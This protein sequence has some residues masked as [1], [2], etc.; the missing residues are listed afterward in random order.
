MMKRF[1]TAPI[2]SVRRL[3]KAAR[4]LPLLALLLAPLV[5]RA[6][7]FA[8]TTT[9]D[10]GMGSL[11]QAILAANAHPGADSIKFSIFDTGAQ[12]ISLSSPLPDITDTVTI[13]GTTQAGYMDRPVV[14]IEGSM[15]LTSDISGLTIRAANCVVRG[16]TFNRFGDAGISLQNASGALIE[17]CLFG[18]DAS[19]SFALGNS[20]GLL[21][22]NASN[23]TIRN[24]AFSGNGY[25]LWLTNQSNGNRITNC[26]IGTDFTGG[27]AVGNVYGIVCD[28]SSANIFDSDIISGNLYTGVT[29]E[30]GASGSQIT[31]CFIG[32]SAFYL[33]LPNGADGADI[34]DSGG[35]TLSNNIIDSNFLDGVL[36]QGTAAQ[37]NILTGNTIL[38]SATGVETQAG[39]SNNVIGGAAAAAGNAIFGNDVAGISISGDGSA[40][41][42]ISSNQIYSNGAY[43]VSI[44]S[45]DNQVTA[46]ILNGNGVNGVFV[47]ASDGSRYAVR[48]P[49]RFNSIYD[50]GDLGIWLDGKGASGANNLQPAPVL[51]T[52]SAVAGNALVLGT[53]NAAPNKT[54][55]IQFF[56]NF[57]PDPSGFGE[58]Q[59][60]LGSLNVTTNATGSASVNTTLNAVDTGLFLSSIVT[61]PD[62]N[63]SAFSNTLLVGQPNDVPVLTALDP[64]TAIVGGAGFTLTVTG[65]NFL[66]NS[67]VNWNGQDLPTQYV[68]ANKLTAT[69]P[70]SDLTSAGNVS[71]TV[72]NAP[73]GGGVSNPLTFTALNPLPAIAAL[74]P[75]SV[76]AGSPA[77]TLK[78]NGSNF[79]KSSVVR[80]N[81][82]DRATTFVSSSQLTIT[83]P[84]TDIATAGT[85]ALTV[86]SPTPG[87]GASAPVTFTINNPVPTL[88]S[89]LPGSAKAGSPSVTITLSGSNFVAK[90]QGQWN[91]A[92]RPTTYVSATQLTLTVPASDLITPG[93]TAVTVFNPAPG[94]GT[95]AAQ[96]FTVV[97]VPDLQVTT[98]GASIGGN[99]I[100]NIYTDQSFDVTWTDAN[101][102]Q[103]K[104]VGPWTDTVTLS[105]SA[106]PGGTALASFSYPYNGSLDAGQS[107]QRIQTMAIPRGNVPADGAYYLIVTTD[108]ANKVDEGGFEN[109]NFRAIP[110]YIAR[111]PLPDLIVAPNGIVAPDTA[112]DQQTITVQYSIKNQGHASTDA[113]Q[114]TD[115]IYLST[116]GQPGIEDAVKI[117]AQNVSY[118]NAGDSYTGSVQM[119]LPRGVVGD[120]YLSVYTDFDGSNHFN[121]PFSVVEED[122]TNNYFRFVNGAA[123][124]VRRPIHINASPYPDLQVTALTAPDTAFRGQPMTL[125]YTVANKG[126]LA[127]PSGQ[128][129]WQD[130]FYL[131]QSTT[132]DP[133]SARFIG[134]TGNLSGLAIGASYVQ[135]SATVTIPN[136]IAGDWYVVAYTDYQNNV[137]EFTAENNNTRYYLDNTGKPKTVHI[138]ANPPDLVIP[139]AV[140]APDTAIAN[141]QISVAWTVK[142]QGA[143]DATPGWFDTVYLT[144][145]TTPDPAK[146]TPLVTVYHDGTVAAGKSYATPATATV[147]IPACIAGTYALYVYTDSRSQIFEYDPNLNAEANNFSPLK[148]VVIT[149]IP[150]DLQVA[151]VT[152]PATGN[153]GQTIPVTFTV[154]NRGIGPT[155]EGSW[156]DTIYLSSSATFN[157]GTTTALA[158]FTHTGDLA[159]GA[160]YTDTES[161]TLPATAQG[162]YYVFVMTDSSNQV[163][164]CS[165]ENNNVGG[166]AVSIIVANQLPDLQINA[167]VA[168]PSAQVGQTISLQWTG[169]NNGQAAAKN[170]AW[171][172]GVYLTPASGGNAIRLATALISGPLAIGG[173]YSAQAQITIPPSTAP[174]SYLL[175]VTADADNFVYEGAYENNNTAIAPITIAAPNDDLQVTAVTA[176]TDAISGQTMSVSWTVKNAGTQPTPAAGWTDYVLL[177]RDQN[178]DASDTIVGYAVHSSV[179]AP[180]ATYTQNLNVTIPLGFSGPFYVFVYTD[181]KN[182]VAE[183]NEF[184]NVTI[185]PNATN[186]TL[187]PPTDLVVLPITPPATAAPGEPVTLNW[188]VKNQGAQTALGRW[189]DAVYFS[190]KSY[191]D[192]TATLVG[193]VD[194]VGN[195]AG[196]A[197]YNGTLTTELPAVTPGNYYVIV[198]TDVRNQVVETDETNNTTVALTQTKVDVLE[199]TLGVP[200]ASTLNNGQQHYYKVN[201]PANETLDFLLQS[202]AA[203]SSNEL[204]ARYGD[205]A[206]LSAYDYLYSNPFQ[207]NQEI[208]VPNTQAGYYYSL[209]RG[210]NVPTAPAPFTIKASIVPFQISSV[211]PSHIGDN[212]QVTITLHGAKFQNGATVQLKQNG[213]TLDAAK[214][215]ATDSATLKARFFFTNAPHGLYDVVLTNPNNA[216]AT[217]AQAMTIETAT[218]LL[219]QLDTSGNLSPVIGRIMNIASTVRN[220]GNVDVP[221][222]IIGSNISQNVTIGTSRPANT[223]PLQSDFPGANSAFASPVLARISDRGSIDTFFIRDLGP[224]DDTSFTFHIQGLVSG[225]YTGSVVAVAEYTSDFISKEKARAELLRQAVLKANSPLPPAIS[226]VVLNSDTWWNY[227]STIL[228]AHGWMNAGNLPYGKANPRDLASACESLCNNVCTAWN[229]TEFIICIATIEFGPE[230]CILEYLVP[231]CEAWAYVCSTICHPLDTC[232]KIY[233]YFAPGSASSFYCCKPRMPSDPNEMVGPT[234]YGP[235]SFVGFQQALPYTVDFENVMTATAAAQKIVVTEQLDPN[236]D[237]RTFRLKEIGFGAYRVTV[238]DNRAF[239]QTRMQLGADLGNLLADITAGVD[240]ATGRVTWTLTAIDP[241][242]GEQPTGALLG[243]LPPNNASNIGQG[244]VTYTVQPKAGTQT[245]TP[246]SAQAT[247]VFDSNEPI[248]TNA[249]TNTLDGVAPTSAIAAL[250]ASTVPTF[251]LSWSGMDDPT[252]SGLASYDVWVSDNGGPYQPFLTGVTTTTATYTGQGG[253]T[254]RFYSLARDNAGNVETKN[255]PDATTTVQGAA[256]VIKLEGV[257]NLGAVVGTVGRVTFQF[258]PTDGSAAFTQSVSLNGDGSFSLTNL[259]A[260]KYT[261]W[262]KGTR[263][264]AKVVPLDLTNGSASNLNATLTAGDANNDNSVDVLDFGILVNAYGGQIGAANSDYDYAADF[265]ADGKIDVQ[266]FGLL[267]NSYG[268]VGD[269]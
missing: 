145:N 205:I 224:G 149:N 62:G 268:S 130:G 226:S 247:I 261:V 123:Q 10:D 132:F 121:G 240:I 34:L 101:A 48:V 47:G 69:V 214:V 164:E 14:E 93:T 254:Y 220:V 150:P 41:N 222:T 108:S 162:T 84:A 151:S 87:G 9:N 209:V 203:D 267:V 160:T 263:W 46:N 117:A 76:I 234:G 192:I 210:A 26:Q 120:Y 238:P 197:T 187:P 65:A 246:L 152:N 177:S 251:T 23:N 217:T 215:W 42:Q 135:P 153:A 18:L 110:I 225:N 168:P 179:L 265:N 167:I 207:P 233:S 29:L 37:R 49:I 40:G 173:T 235:Q 264:L 95:S 74:D 66:S 176:P 228:V 250:P 206:S 60:Y 55:E 139:L 79:V 223:F 24:S 243:L 56:T 169:A 5:A 73:P 133:A 16:L 156:S 256:G 158:S 61:D 175:S 129:A 68:S 138:V 86:F 82:S 172:D 15:A 91:G 99:A 202:S 219:V 59:I 90:S 245:G 116:D 166:S 218:A 38:N 124:G 182:A 32:L 1:E 190:K 258:R 180:G 3:A 189:T 114:W 143:F 198:R 75:G 106:Q 58:G 107:S 78:I 19:G 43:G 255:A 94:G 186:V 12:T 200:L 259:P 248:A 11:R 201:A 21:L 77:F 113:G 39:A 188:T 181:W 45:A 253:H 157:T 241:L 170:P 17:K 227:V 137:Y 119:T 140:T 27:S 196:G 125:A 136:D 50:N 98:L 81:G 96:P 208:V 2:F 141:R 70:A 103:A 237:W 20:Y 260:K 204:Y 25:G 191:W 111:R 64:A 239:Y 185:A 131:T 159:V 163:N 148:P 104:A 28:A 269:L 8:V 244:Y 174:G 128:N 178:F 147:T 155:I 54:Y 67:V 97:S 249:V 195:L 80:W 127:T 165:N 154:T 171:N 193:R 105:T 102:G 31:N 161:V 232:C 22:S 72:F 118:L 33:P 44:T 211:T 221:Y 183:S 57:S 126:T 252:G 52:A 231:V 115:W 112:F 262:I 212:G 122:E 13:D 36:L 213:I 146:D 71:V 63:T 83:V 242:T 194:H 92:V 236:M 144:Q 100:S 6:D 4:S 109:N 89:L 88:S 85:A 184:N 35:N 230:V 134:S 266:D 51:L 257:P 7:V 199:L 142:N 216:V 229:I 53:L 30:Q